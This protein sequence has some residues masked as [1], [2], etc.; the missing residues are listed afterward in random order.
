MSSKPAFG[1]GASG[2]EGASAF[3]REYLTRHQV[4]ERYPIS[5][6]TLAKLAANGKGPRFFKP[7]DK[8]LY[9]P[10][11]IEAWIEASA[12]LPVEVS[13]KE[14]GTTPRPRSIRKMT[15]RG[16]AQPSPITLNLP[17]NGR[18]SLP[19]SPNSWLRRTD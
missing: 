17:K 12:V 2:S 10:Q 4:A 9:R 8:C 3:T 7:I 18:K 5:V 11:D 19:P 1:E 15:G 16:R 13:T 14:V 6:H